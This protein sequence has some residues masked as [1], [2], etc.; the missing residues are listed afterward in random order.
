MAV[1]NDIESLE[2]IKIYDKGV[3]AP[4]Y[5]N[6]YGEFQLSYRYGDILIPN[7]RQVEPLKVECQHFLDCITNQYQ[8][9][10][11]WRRWSKRGENPGNCSKIFDRI[12][13][14]WKS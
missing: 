8:T 10:Q 4:D 9:Y 5:T 13:D 7:I 14:T 11:Q 1:Y 3:E 2:K 12:T 6:G